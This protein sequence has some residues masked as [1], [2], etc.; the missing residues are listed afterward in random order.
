MSKVGSHMLEKH[1]KFE[2]SGILLII[3]KCEPR[4]GYN[5]NVEISLSGVLLSQTRMHRR[6]FIQK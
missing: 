6:V 3:A 2:S 1:T 5:L 4:R